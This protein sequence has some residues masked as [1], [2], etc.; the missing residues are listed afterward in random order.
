[1]D[2]LFGVSMDNMLDVNCD[3]IG[4]IIVGEPLSTGVGLISANLVGGAAYLYTGKADGT[5]NATP[6]WTVENQ[7]SADLGINAASLLGYSVSGAQYINGHSNPVRALI[8]SPGQALD[9]G[10]GL[11]NLGGT[12]S[13]LFNFTS[14]ND[15]IGK[16]YTYPV[17][18]CT[19]LPVTL[20]DFKT[21]VVDCSVFLDWSIASQA[22]LDHIDIEESN[23]AA[24]YTLFRKFAT[25]S[26]GDYSV[27]VPQ[28]SP[29]AYYRLK[30][31]NKDGSY[32]YS[33][34]AIATLNCTPQSKLELYPNPLKSGST[35]ILY[36]STNTNEAGSAS[37][38]VMD[39]YG[40]RLINQ[41]VTIITGTNT[42]NINCDQLP[43][44]QYYIQ[45]T[46]SNWKSDPL[47]FVKM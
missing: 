35:T 18:G 8:G 17:T 14:T 7:V 12:F 26:A 34:V 11:L 46:G 40:R 41:S 10:S 21:D 32:S 39:V 1:V 9:F 43:A 45:I 42:M 5:Y 33:D 30:L 6:I 28:Q 15:N 38:T 47:K 44:G 25:V 20:S 29:S 4:D 19:I 24:T 27:N 3:G 36:N 13:T 23:D 22:S 16:A 31:I 37:V 2:A